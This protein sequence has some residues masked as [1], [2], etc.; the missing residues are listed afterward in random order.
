MIFI[1]LIT[2]SFNFTKF[3]FNYTQIRP[4]VDELIYSQSISFSFGFVAIAA[5]YSLFYEKYLS[6]YSILFKTCN[7]FLLLTFLLLSFMGGGRG[8]FLVSFLVVFYYL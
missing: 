6:R 8:E 3:D 5:S 7:L 4:L 2:K 1:F